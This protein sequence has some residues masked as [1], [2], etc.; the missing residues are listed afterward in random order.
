MREDIIKQRWMM[1]DFDSFFTADRAFPHP[2][3][4]EVH[5]IL[6]RQEWSKELLGSPC[7][8]TFLKLRRMRLEK[9]QLIWNKIT[10][11]EI[12]MMDART[13]FHEWSDAFGN[14]F[15]GMQVPVHLGKLIENSVGN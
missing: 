3:M 2:Y 11:P 13:R 9:F 5:Y 8:R 15:A 1:D 4:H 6:N 10:P 14:F 12:K 7:L